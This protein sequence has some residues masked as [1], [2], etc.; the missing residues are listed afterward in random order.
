MVEVINKLREEIESALSTKAHPMA[1]PPTMMVGVIKGG[2]QVNVVPDSCCIDI[3]R[4]VVPGE[5][6]DDLLAEVDALLRQVGDENPDFHIERKEPYIVDP[7]LDTSPDSEIAR[8]ALKSCDN[9]LGGGELGAVDYGSD[10]SKLNTVADV[11]A[12]V[13][14]PGSIDQAHSA[15]EWVPIDEL[16]SCSELYAEICRTFGKS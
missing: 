15:D 12:I 11:P 9:I 2:L 4:R 7:P 13:L 10:A 3:D 1:G 14:G 5:D 16:V 8:A 6:A